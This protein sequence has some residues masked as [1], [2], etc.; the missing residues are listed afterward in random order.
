M[1]AS[2]WVRFTASCEKGAAHRV[3]IELSLR[4]AASERSFGRRFRSG[5]FIS[6][7]PWHIERPWRIRTI[8]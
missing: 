1:D 8:L 3:L 2:L 5:E 4:H 7:R 6:W